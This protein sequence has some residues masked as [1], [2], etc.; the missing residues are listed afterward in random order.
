MEIGMN[1]NSVS[2]NGHH[3]RP[4]LWRG[5]VIALC[6]LIFS[7]CRGP[8][9][10]QPPAPCPP[11]CPSPEACPAPCPGAAGL[12]C[13][14]QQTGC[15]NC[16]IPGGAWAPPGIQKPWPRNE[17]VCDG[18]DTGYPA[19][20][21]PDWELR[22]FEPTDTVAHFDTLEGETIVQPSNRVCLY[23]PRF[24]SVRKVTGVASDQQ[25]IQLAGVTKPIQINRVDDI[26]PVEANTQNLETVR[27]VATKGPVVAESEQTDG[28]LSR[29]QG[30]GV[31]AGGGVP[32]EN[33]LLLGIDTLEETDRVL[34]AEGVAAAIVWSD[35][36]GVDVLLDTQKAAESVL[37]QEA[38]AIYTVDEPPACPK[39]RL[40][41]CASTA[42]A[43]PG[44]TVE[45]VIRFDNVGNQPIGNVVIADNLI[46][47][48]ECDPESL[49]CTLPAKF[50]TKKNES[51]SVVVRCELTD[52]LA[53][54]SG[55]ILKFRCTVR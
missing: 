34:V 4:A 1:M 49:S 25:N 2:A 55:G 32:F 26:Q 23:A 41:K 16:G 37:D 17:Y 40:I 22:G 24:G 5:L 39:L 8:S 7:A 10:L 54:G 15:M 43:K 50:E 11:P 3:Y 36:Q 27:A 20:V 13:P 45:F 42:A 53:V 33:L 31:S 29:K 19:T 12:P 30:V 46:G 9:M 38:E 51:G 14:P 6:T 21:T 28:A 52:P 18:G 35:P 47:R 48:L 44:E